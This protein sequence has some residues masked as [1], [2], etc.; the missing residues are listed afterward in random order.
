M[1]LVVSLN[2]ALDVT[3]RVDHADWAGVNRPAEVHVRPGGKGVNVATV[4]GALGAEVL[5]T[6]LAGGTAGNGL[7]AGLSAR[8]VAADWVEISAETRRTFA[9]V[10]SGRGQTALFNEPGPRVRP[11]E[12][13]R[14]KGT[15]RA[16]LAGCTAVVLSGSMPPGLPASTYADLIRMAAD[17]GVPTLLDASGEA[18]ILGAAAGPAIVKPNLAE[19]QAAATRDPAAPREHTTWSDRAGSWCCDPAAAA[20]K[21]A[22]TLRG[23]GA[24]AVVVTLGSDGLLALTPE[25][26]WHARPSE[27]IGGNPTG[28][29]DAAAAGLAHG[30]AA[31]TPWPDRAAHAAALGAA[32][33]AAPIAGEI[34]LDHYQR[35]LA[36]V[37]VGAARQPWH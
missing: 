18:L 30:L 14:F 2:P 19:M 36:G 31:G 34:D 22:D 33:V 26:S 8:T 35:A 13:A 24:A 3:H 9:V 29:G 27:V 16:Q 15:F 10:D 17:A 37:Q 6:G 32:A 7:R 23:T 12:Y 5:L 4:L 21:A 11:D 28:A 20:A 1:I 25:E